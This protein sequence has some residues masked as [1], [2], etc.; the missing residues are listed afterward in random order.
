MKIETGTRVVDMTSPTPE[1][2]TAPSGTLRQIFSTRQV[3]TS[4]GRAVVTH[5]GSDSVT[6]TVRPMAKLD[7]KLGASWNSST[8]RGA[9]KVR[10]RWLMTATDLTAPATTAGLVRPVGEA[11]AGARQVTGPRASPRPH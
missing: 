1:P 9:R 5:A 2:L 8:A 3:T 7:V 4:S 11:S 6:V 10:T